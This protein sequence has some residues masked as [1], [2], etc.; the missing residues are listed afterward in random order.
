MSEDTKLP[1]P[2]CPAMRAGLA[3]DMERVG[4]TESQIREIAK[5]AA[6]AE[7]I[8]CAATIR[9]LFANRIGTAE[10]GGYAE[11]FIRMA[12]EAIRARGTK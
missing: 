8:A 7:R 1:E 12:D 3:P 9:S 6:E 2:A 4:W 11:T 5:Q 10:W